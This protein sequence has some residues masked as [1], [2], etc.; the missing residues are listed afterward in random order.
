MVTNLPT[1]AALGGNLEAIELMFESGLDLT[2]EDYLQSLVRIGVKSCNFQNYY[3]Y[4]SIHLKVSDFLNVFLIYFFHF[5]TVSFQQIC[6]K[7]NLRYV[8]RIK[9]WLVLQVVVLKCMIN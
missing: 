9:K 1:E 2:W 8:V 7:C 3:S 6:L 4:L 5:F